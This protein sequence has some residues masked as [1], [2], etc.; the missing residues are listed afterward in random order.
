MS[1]F[2]PEIYNLDN[3]H[4]IDREEAEYWRDEFLADL[5]GALDNLLSPDPEDDN[6][7]EKIQRSVIAEYIETVKEW[8]DMT[9]TEFCV[10][11]IDS[12]EDEDEDEPDEA[13]VDPDE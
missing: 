11:R 8:L 5:D 1:Y 6:E 3:L 10:S 2:D 12:Y 7:L 9:I 13:E 4:D